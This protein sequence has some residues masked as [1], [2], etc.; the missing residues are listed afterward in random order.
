MGLLLDT[1]YSV[2]CTILEVFVHRHDSYMSILVNDVI[3]AVFGTDNCV[4]ETA[5]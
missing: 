4:P 1:L 3:L 2:R 5:V